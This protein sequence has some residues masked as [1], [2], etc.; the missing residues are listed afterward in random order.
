M[1]QVVRVFIDDGTFG[2]GFQF[3]PGGLVLGGELRIVGRSTPLK[4]RDSR[5]LARWLH[6]PA[7]EYPWPTSVKGTALDRFN[8]DNEPVALT[9]VEPVVVEVSADTAWSSR[10]FRHPLR[11]LRVRPELSPADVLSDSLHAVSPSGWL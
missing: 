7:G 4:T 2:S 10:S 6:P 8:R 5:E 9:L 3:L 1:R 11:V